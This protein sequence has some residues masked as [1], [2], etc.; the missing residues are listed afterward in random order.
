MHCLKKKICTGSQQLITQP[1]R[2][3]K[4]G[5]NSEN[6]S[7]PIRQCCLI[8]RGNGYNSAESFNRKIHGYVLGIESEHVQR[9]GAKL[10]KAAGWRKEGIALGDHRWLEDGGHSFRG[11]PFDRE[12][13]SLACSSVD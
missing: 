6:K 12:E 2:Y 3:D 10:S 5:T 1:Q 4:K 8:N 9:R 13:L 11:S 7:H